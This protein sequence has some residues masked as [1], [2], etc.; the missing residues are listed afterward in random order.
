MNNQERGKKFIEE[1]PKCLLCKN[2]AMVCAAF[3]KDS[4][5]SQENEVL[6]GLCLRHFKKIDDDKT[7]IKIEEILLAKDFHQ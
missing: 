5:I 1:N 7:M 6:Y 4:V 2:R 3:F